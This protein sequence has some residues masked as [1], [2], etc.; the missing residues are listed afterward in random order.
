MEN[1]RNAFYARQDEFELLAVVNIKSDFN[2]RTHSL[3]AA[4]EGAN[5]CAGLA[6]D[7]GDGRKH[8]GTILSENAQAH[9]KSSRRFTGPLDRNAAFGVIK[10]I[11]HVGARL[12]VNG[13]S[14]TSGDIAHNIIARDGIATLRAI[15]HQVV[16]ATN[17]DRALVHP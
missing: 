7:V 10:K 15:D 6:N 1:A 11:L 2:A 4:F 14:P 5:I 9:R 8:A 12:A 17:E 16:V 13:D 3:A